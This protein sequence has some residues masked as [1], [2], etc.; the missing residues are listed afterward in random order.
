M[1]A[2]AYEINVWQMLYAQYTQLYLCW[3]IEVNIIIMI[4]TVE[5]EL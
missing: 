3:K 5:L 4:I 1:Q 2:D